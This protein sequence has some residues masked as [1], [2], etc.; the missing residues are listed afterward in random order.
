MTYVTLGL[1]TILWGLEGHRHRFPCAAYSA[2]HVRTAFC[3]EPTAF[4][5]LC[6]QHK[7]LDTDACSWGSS[8]KKKTK[9]Y[10]ITFSTACDLVVLGL[11]EWFKLTGP[12]CCALRWPLPFIFNNLL[13]PREC[14]LDQQ[15]Y[16]ASV[17]TYY[18]LHQHT[19]STTTNAHS[20]LFLLHMLI[21]N[22]EPIAGITAADCFWQ[23]S[24]STPA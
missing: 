20:V 19:R 3:T 21:F 13:E 4:F 23:M 8:S 1:C 11:H 18:S 14:E 9:L 5:Q 22:L 24:G 7:T 2:G 16:P 10:W 6:T 17:S 15:D 12:T